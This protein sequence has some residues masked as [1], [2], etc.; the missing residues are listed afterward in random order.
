MP[1]VFDSLGCCCSTVA[2]AIM[3]EKWCVSLVCSVINKKTALCELVNC[4]RALGL[5]EH[6]PSERSVWLCRCPNV[7]TDFGM[8]WNDTISSNSRLR[9]H[10]HQPEH[11]VPSRLA[12]PMAVP[13][14]LCPHTFVDGKQTQNDIHVNN[15]SDIY[16]TNFIAFW[17]G[18]FFSCAVWIISLLFVVVVS[19]HFSALTFCLPFNVYLDWSS[20]APMIATIIA[21]PFA[22]RFFF[23]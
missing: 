22:V 19:S 17:A 5:S 13:A 14:R 21:H 18:L 3:C 15:C 9:R 23:I 4:N 12:F 7:N 6:T 20:N 8:E 11:S 2:L 16:R 1:F 10:T